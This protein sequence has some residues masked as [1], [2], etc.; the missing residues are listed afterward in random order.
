[1]RVIT[2]RDHLPRECLFARYFTVSPRG[3]K[4]ESR[5]MRES[6]LRLNMLRRHI[7]DAKFTPP[8]ECT[9]QSL[10][11]RIRRIPFRSTQI[12]FIISNNY[13]QQLPRRSQISLPQHAVIRLQNKTWPT[14]RLEINITKKRGPKINTRTSQNFSTSRSSPSSIPGILYDSL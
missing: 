8:L 13:E 10:N 3:K 7:I 2:K 14:K 12:P 11:G 6:H 5:R 4:S 9:L 1:M